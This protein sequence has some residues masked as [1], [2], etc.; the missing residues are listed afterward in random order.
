MATTKE[1]KVYP[2]KWE[3][4]NRKGKKVSGFVQAA[5]TRTAKRELQR[6]GINAIK[7]RRKSQGV[8]ARWKDA[9][10]PADIAIITRQV[11]TM[12]AAGVPLVQ[13]LQIIARSNEKNSIRELTG[14]IAADVEGGTPLSQ[15][16]QKHPRYFDE[17]Y[18]DLVQSGEQ[19]GSL[20]H[21]FDQIALYREKAEAIK[22]KIR[23]AMFYPIMVL[24]VAFAVTAILL[25][26]V[27][28]QFEEIFAGFGATLPAFTQLVINLSRWLQQYWLFILIALV[29]GGWLYVRAWR[30]SQKVRD[31]TDR[32]ILRLPVVGKILHK[33]ALARFAR[34]LAT[35]FSAGIPLVEG[36]LSAAGASG[37][38]VYREAVKQMRD[39]VIAGMQMNLAMRATGLFPDMVVQMVMIGEESGAIDDMMHKVAGIYEREVD[40]AVDGLTSL[41]EPLIMVVL[42]VLVGGL[43]IAMYLPIFN[44]G[45]VVR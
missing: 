2:F 28:P 27:I 31:A 18:C 14:G 17:L 1:L 11:A 26:F 4:I 42:G 25:L 7:V 35:T 40:D 43:V 21:I 37:N 30:N 44:L 12:L 13:T 5:D 10:K 33:A 9:I 15:A 16:L 29:I 38:V 32:F 24:L 8:L 20:E 39:E 19:T 41:I 22:S 34:T 3:G 6:Q 36:L 23:K 45:S